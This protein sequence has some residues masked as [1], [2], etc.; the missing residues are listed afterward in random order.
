MIPIKPIEVESDGTGG[1]FGKHRG[2][3]LKDIRDRFELCEND[4]SMRSIS[5]VLRITREQ[6]EARGQLGIYPSLATIA[7]AICLASWILRF[8]LTGDFSEL[9][10]KFA[11]GSG[12]VGVLLMLGVAKVWNPR[13][14]NLR[15]EQIIREL[16]AKSINTILQ[17]QPP[18]KPLLR[19][20]RDTVKEIVRKVS[21]SG[22]VAEL[23]QVS[24]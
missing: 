2:I 8:V 18:L 9:A 6:L 5:A 10:Q 11:I 24:E 7:F 23:L 22:Q 15:Q 19:E 20:Q 13:R 4:P 21:D 1:G 3:T 12:A 17:S 16:A 14:E